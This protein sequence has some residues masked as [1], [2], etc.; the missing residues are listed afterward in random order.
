MA[1]NNTKNNILTG[2]IIVAIFTAIITTFWHS[3]SYTDTTAGKIRTEKSQEH[4]AI[5]HD[6]EILD[7]KTAAII[8]KMDERQREIKGILTRIEVYIEENGK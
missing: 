1:N 6:I 2:I 4:T 8:E 7:K 3:I 5:K